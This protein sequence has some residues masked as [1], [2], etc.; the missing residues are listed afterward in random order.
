MWRASLCAAERR[1]IQVAHNKPPG[2]YLPVKNLHFIKDK[3]GVK[4]S[5]RCGKLSRKELNRLIRF[6]EKLK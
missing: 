3:N 2:V 6:L 4:V 1:G 5:A